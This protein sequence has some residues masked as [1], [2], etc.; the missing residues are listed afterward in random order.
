[1]AGIGKSAHINSSEGTECVY[2][3]EVI[4]RTFKKSFLR[5]EA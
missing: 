4:G 3:H 5:V 1:M 2:V